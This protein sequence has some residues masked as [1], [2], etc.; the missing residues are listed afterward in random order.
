MKK[1]K[2]VDDVSLSD[3]ILDN[4]VEGLCSG[5]LISDRFAL[6]AAHCLED[7]DGRWVKMKDHLAKYSF[8]IVKGYI[9]KHSQ[10]CSAKIMEISSICR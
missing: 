2:V 5:L 8:G 9:I 10:Q 7:S 3:E 1:K 4:T 6:T